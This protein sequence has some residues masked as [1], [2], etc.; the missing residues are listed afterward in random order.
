MKHATEQ[1]TNFFE[2][3][4][5]EVFEVCSLAGLIIVSILANF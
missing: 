3:M 4:E 2:F 1:D 5:S